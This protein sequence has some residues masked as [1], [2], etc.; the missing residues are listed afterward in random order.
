[1]KLPFVILRHSGC[2]SLHY[3][4]MLS[5]GDAL[6]TWQ[7]STRPQSA[8]PGQSVRARRLADHRAAYLT[9]EGPVSRNRGQVKRIDEGSYECIE[10]TPLR[11]AV[12]LEGETLVGRF[13]LARLDESSDE[14]SFQRLCE[15]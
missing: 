14:W 4:L 6:A 10:K 13:E 12:R 5:D 11:W 1:M 3:D 7:L 8:A 15:D 2:G 9:Y